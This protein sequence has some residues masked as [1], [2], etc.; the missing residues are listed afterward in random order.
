MDPWQQIGSVFGCIALVGAFIYWHFKTV[1]GFKDEIHKQDL[2]IKDLESSDKLQQQTIDQLNGLFPV[3]K[4]AI[5]M[6]EKKK[7]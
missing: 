3:L 4:Q 5:D 7:K 1:N 6:L 2:R